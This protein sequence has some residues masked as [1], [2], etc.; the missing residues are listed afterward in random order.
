MKHN[1]LIKAAMLTLALTTSVAATQA[2]AGSKQKPPIG[3]EETS[4]WYSIFWSF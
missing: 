3:T 2:H 1:T 4:S